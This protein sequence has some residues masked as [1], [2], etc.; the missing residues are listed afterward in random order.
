[1]KKNNVAI[2]YVGITGAGK[3]TLVKRNLTNVHPSRLL[4]YDVQ[5]EYKT[6]PDNYE[7][8]DIDIFQNNV[9]N[10]RN[11]HA[12]FEEATMF[13]SNRG[14]DEN[15]IK[16]L[17]NKRHHNNVI[18][19]CFHSIADIPGN[20]FKHVTYVYLLQTNDVLDVVEKRFPKLLNAW[21]LVNEHPLKADKLILPN[22]K[23]TPYK[24]VKTI[25]TVKFL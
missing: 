16:I 8:P 2:I 23:K 25:E 3:S 20:I 5:R 21:K 13:F 1:M 9:H 10:L 14:R 22:G 7:L 17:V 18:H 4:V 24:L 12:V 6:Y 11:G 15:M 19:L